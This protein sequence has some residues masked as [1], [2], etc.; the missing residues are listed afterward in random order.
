MLPSIGRQRIIAIISCVL[1][2]VLLL[3]SFRRSLPAFD[4][5][6]LPLRRP[7]AS[8]VVYFHNDAFD[9]SSSSS[10]PS[11]SPSPP[12]SPSLNAPKV[13]AIIET[14]PLPNLIPLILHFAAVLGP[15]WPIVVFT[16]SETINH[17]TSAAAFQRYTDQGRFFLKAL[18]PTTSFNDRESVSTFLTKP[19][20]WEQLAPTQNILLFQAD[21]ILCA[22]APKT[23]EDFLEYDFVGAPISSLFGR[24]YN[25]GLSLR[26]RAMILEI[27][28]HSNWSD[29][30]QE[31]RQA[32]HERAKS[33]PP[34]DSGGVHEWNLDYE[35]QWFVK[36]MSELGTDRGSHQGQAPAHLPSQDVAKTFAV[37]T[38]AYDRPLGY[39]QAIRWQKNHLADIE[40][41][42]PEYKLCFSEI[43]R[44]LP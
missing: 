39:H 17:F 44:D 24:G 19:W 3:F 20:L 36:K 2:S 6:V 33:Q 12:P 28:R 41:W 14:R 11:P 13:A 25:G 22:N 8:S 26:N 7:E 16:S 27:L 10:S 23:V 37:E 34:E 42:C 9:S 4:R 18:P 5:S 38:I 31:F 30:V 40:R 43:E 15:E 29:E 35:D 32:K 1:L 21:S